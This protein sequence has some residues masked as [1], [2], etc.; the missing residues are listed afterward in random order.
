M[1][2]PPPASPARAPLAPVAPR[3]SLFLISLA[4]VP[5][6][7]LVSWMCWAHWPAMT[8]SFVL[9][10]DAGSRPALHSLPARLSASTAPPSSS[11][12]TRTAAA[13]CGQ[14]EVHQRPGLGVHVRLLGERVLCA[15]ACGV[16]VW[17][18]LRAPGVFHCP[19]R[20]ARALHREPRLHAQ[21][22]DLDGRRWRHLRQRVER[23][24]CEAQLGRRV[25]G[26]H[27]APGVLLVTVFGALPELAR[28][29][30]TVFTLVRYVVP[31]SNLEHFLF[32]ANTARPL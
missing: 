21:V 20:F 9:N 10:K 28:V 8:A 32:A 24:L 29:Y 25:W 3:V 23:G 18:A 1:G 4:G 12:P 22:P 13:L 16:R 17:G 2:P 11:S 26:P 6:S 30:F 14:L 15:A 7:S 5:G 27:H 19:W 31:F